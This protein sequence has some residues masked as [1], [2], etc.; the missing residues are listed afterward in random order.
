MYHRIT[1]D[2][3]FSNNMW[4]INKKRFL[5]QM[6]FL[7]NSKNLNIYSCE[8][9]LKKQNNEIAVSLSFDDGT[10]DCYE[11]VAPILFELKI[12]FTIFIITNFA[13]SNKYGYMNIK[14][15]RELVSN[16]LVK[17]GSHSANHLNL[18]TCSEYQLK[19]ELLESKNYLEDSLGMEISMISYPFGKYNE[20]VQKLTQESKYKFAFNSDFSRILNKNNRYKIPRTEIW[21]T[22]TINIF[23]EK[24]HGDWDWLRYSLSK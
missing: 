19:E 15:I 3:F 10:I 17:I 2:N 24:L 1:T 9:I 18:S 20:K 6:N 12:P 7:V 13:K 4:S 22:D 16:P 5:E 11:I 23:R 21:N 8:E 14:Q